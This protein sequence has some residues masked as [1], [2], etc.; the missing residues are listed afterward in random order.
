MI[1][2]KNNTLKNQL[3]EKSNL[4]SEKNALIDKLYSQIGSSA[5]EAVSRQEGQKKS[6]AR[7]IKIEVTDFSTR[8][9][10]A[11]REAGIND[12]DTL[13][14]FPSFDDIMCLPNFGQVT[15]LEIAC[16]MYEYGYTAWVRFAAALTNER[17]RAIIENALN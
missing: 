3:L 1:I 15:I 17:L 16:K 10:N 4:L 14:S 2:E 12:Y 8:T 9:Y 7:K 13:L 11:L 5:E 6:H